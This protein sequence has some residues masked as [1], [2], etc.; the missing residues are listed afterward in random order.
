VTQKSNLKTISFFVLAFIVFFL[1]IGFL[2][3]G[4]Y[5][6]PRQYPLVQLEDGWTVS[7]GDKVFH[8]DVLSDADVGITTKD[9]QLVLSRTLP[10]YSLSPATIHFRTILSSTEVYLD[11]ELIYSYGQDYAQQGHMLPKYQNFVILPDDFA[12]KTLKIVITA[13]ERNAFSGVSPVTLGNQE[14][15]ARYMVQNDRLALS[16]GVFLVVFGIVLLI[17]SPYLIFTARHDYSIAFSG[18][19]SVTMGIYILCYNDLFWV[20]SDQP[21][22]YTFIEYFSLFSIP[23]A[24]LGF[25]TSARQIYNSIIGVI[26]WIVNLG[27]SLMTALLHILNLVHI[28][29]FVQWLHFIALVEGVY[30]IISLISTMVKKNRTNRSFFQTN[31]STVMLILGLILLLFCSVID[32]I[33]FNVLKFVSKGEVNASINFMT[34][35]AL[36]FMICLVLNYFF[37]CAESI[38]EA[39]LQLQLEGLAY[40]DSLTGLFNR[41]KCEVALAELSGDYTIVSIDLD[42]L[43]YTNDNYGHAAGDK[44]LSGFAEILKNSFTDAG[45]IGRM[46][47]DEF[48]VVLPYT[49]EDRIERDFKCFEDLMTYRSSLDKPIKYSASYGKACN[50]DI[51]SESDRTP[52]NVY[53]LAD[54]RMY[55]MKNRHHQD[56]FG[57]LYDDLLKSLVEKGGSANE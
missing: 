40:S 32:I 36:M 7:R 53:M 21:S 11:D 57:R 28:C 4:K 9:Q 33:K 30:V 42:Y 39:S 22:F 14:E 23:A 38:N 34:V 48:I 18:F 19:I 29:H 44:L 13:H 8:P 52:Q 54:A 56:S 45:L 50:S 55:E 49:D 35:G 25:L 2:G 24:I 41:S 5:K 47:G 31:A 43:K 51:S 12:G 3:T 37:H 46:G 16:I 26:L 6:S 10:D 1:V 20:F 17:L 15:L 27:F